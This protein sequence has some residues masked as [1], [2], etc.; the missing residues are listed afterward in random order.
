MQK[1][2]VRLDGFSTL[3][4]EFFF[5]ILSEQG[6]KSVDL[7]TSPPTTLFVSHPVAAQAHPSSVATGPR[8]P[9]YT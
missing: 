9:S 3:K 5:T 6:R 4:I 7:T 1:S 8:R 2:G